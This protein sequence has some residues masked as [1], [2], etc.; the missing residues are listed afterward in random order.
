M[1]QSLTLVSLEVG[2]GG[3]TSRVVIDPIQVMCILYYIV[4]CRGRLAPEGL[5]NGEDQPTVDTSSGPQHSNKLNKG[6]LLKSSNGR[7]NLMGLR[8]FRITH[9]CKLKEVDCN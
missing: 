9:L 3:L 5:Y 2:P 1:M 8:G 6:F 4:H 7:I